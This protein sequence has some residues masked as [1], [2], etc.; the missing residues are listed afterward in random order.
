ME[1]LHV[2][3][4]SSLTRLALQ[5]S[6]DVPGTSQI[7]IPFI[8]A[9]VSQGRDSIV[10]LSQVTFISS[11]GVALLLGTMKGLRRKGAKLILL[12]PSPNVF[13]VLAVSGL[14]GILTIA[15]DEAE[16]SQLLAASAAVS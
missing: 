3:S 15:G 12:A 11:L 4:E 8:A 9:T 6:L 2:P 1:L 5:G 13:K 7:E 14:L 10:D 16:L